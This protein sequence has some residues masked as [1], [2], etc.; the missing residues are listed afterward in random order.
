MDFYITEKPPSASLLEQ[1][2]VS[3]H[4]SSVP[5]NNICDSENAVK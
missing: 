2:D 1:R 5:I 4:F 3:I